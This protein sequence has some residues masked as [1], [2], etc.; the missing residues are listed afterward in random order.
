MAAEPI[1]PSTYYAQQS[2]MTDPRGQADLFL[3]L[4]TD[5]PALRNIIRGLMIHYRNEALYGGPLPPA[6]LAEAQTRYSAKILARIREL[7]PRS[8][9]LPRPSDK[10]FIGCCRDY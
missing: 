10:R 2:F 7:D 5:I 3:D 9:A 6:R 4:P 8:L 1:S